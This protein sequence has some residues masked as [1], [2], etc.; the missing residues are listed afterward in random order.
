[1]SRSLSESSREFVTISFGLFGTMQTD[2]T[3]CLWTR[4]ISC[5]S[6]AVRV[7][8]S[9]TCIFIHIYTHTHTLSLSLSNTHKLSPSLCLSL[10]PLSLSLSLSHTHRGVEVD[11]DKDGAVGS[12]GA[13]VARGLTVDALQHQPA[14]HVHSTN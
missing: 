7:S 8:H 2:V 14:M 3:G 9:R 4:L 5:A 10:P 6:C 1:M 13:I 11:R 12:H